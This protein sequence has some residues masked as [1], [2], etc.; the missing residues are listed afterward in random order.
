MAC[1]NPVATAGYARTFHVPVPPHSGRLVRISTEEHTDRASAAHPRSFNDSN[2]FEDGHDAA[3]EATRQKSACQGRQERQEAKQ[4]GDAGT[5]RRC[6]GKASRTRERAGLRCAPETA[7]ASEQ[8]AGSPR[9]PAAG[10]KGR[11]AN[12]ARRV[13]RPRFHFATA[14]H[15]IN[16]RSRRACSRGSP[17]PPDRAE[18]WQNLARPPSGHR[19]LQS[20]ATTS[21]VRWVRKQDRC[22]QEKPIEPSPDAREPARR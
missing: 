19:S 16:L 13:A 7:T 8:V 18:G 4:A 1:A 22:G 14:I 15:G 6:R 21:I 5:R 2:P 9:L 17:H 20:H 12:P 3:T 10:T 11:S